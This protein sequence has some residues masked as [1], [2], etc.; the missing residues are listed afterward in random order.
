M[1]QG[2]E[3]GVYDLHEGKKK[4]SPCNTAAGTLRV[5]A[6]GREHTDTKVTGD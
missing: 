6:K 2:P 1:S 5:G 3:S 4:C